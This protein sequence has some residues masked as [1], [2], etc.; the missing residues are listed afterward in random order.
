MNCRPWVQILRIL[1]KDTKI[2]FETHI[3]Y[4]NICH[5][6]FGHLYLL[7]VNYFFSIK[8]FHLDLRNFMQV[9]WATLSMHIIP[10][11]NYSHTHMVCHFHYWVLSCQILYSCPKY[12]SKIDG[13]APR[14]NIN[15]QSYKYR[16]FCWNVTS[17]SNLN[18]HM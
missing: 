15:E 18:A 5:L 9:W 6:L 16:E 1:I 10:P 14:I 13:S 12:I 7:H 2:I 11:P 8:L 17:T 4:Q 3:F